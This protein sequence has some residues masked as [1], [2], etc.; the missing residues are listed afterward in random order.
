MDVLVMFNPEDDKLLAGPG[1]CLAGA[2]LV[3]FVD[4]VSHHV[5]MYNVGPPSYKL[6]HKPH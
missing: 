4:L 5:D 2:L 6:L 1:W 3:M